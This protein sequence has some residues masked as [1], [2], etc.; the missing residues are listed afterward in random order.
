MCGLPGSG[1]SHTARAIA[2]ALGAAIIHSDVV[3]KRLAGIAA[4][5]RVPA[6]RVD[7]VYGARMSQETYDA[8]LRQAGALLAEGRPVVADATFP[9][10]RSRTPF[11]ELAASRSVPWSVVYLHCPQELIER[12]LAARGRDP[13]EYSDAD[14]E[15]YRKAAAHF[16][17]PHEAGAH[18]LALCGADD[19]EP[20]VGLVLEKLLDQ[21]PPSG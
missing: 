10:E 12:R 5:R 6:E 8:M 11:L 17:P 20:A 1:K 4:T 7:E 18:L 13:G 19:P 14:L 16:E 15:V 9:H 2:R 3:R 21:A